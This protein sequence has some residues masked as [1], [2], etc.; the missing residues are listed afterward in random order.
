MK[1]PLVL[2]TAAALSA[3]G[4]ATEQPWSDQDGTRMGLVYAVLAADAITAARIHDAPPNVVEAGFPAKQ[5]FGERPDAAE[6]IALSVGLA[7]AYRAAA[8]RLP[9]KWRKRAQYF[10]IGTHSY[11]LATNCDNGLC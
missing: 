9:E 3:S 11:G 7:F 1:L 4:C 8:K 5:L 6:V 2:A 10:V